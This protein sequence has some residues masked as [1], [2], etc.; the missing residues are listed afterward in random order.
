MPYFSAHRRLQ[1][2]TRGCSDCNK[3]PEECKW[4]NCQKAIKKPGTLRDLTG[5][6]VPDKHDVV[7]QLKEQQT[8]ADVSSA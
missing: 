8:L 5:H 6:L 2:F 7:R 3:Y 1:A 4:E